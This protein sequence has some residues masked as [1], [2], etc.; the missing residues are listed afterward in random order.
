[1]IQ[2][3]VDQRLLKLVLDNH[4]DGIVIFDN[5]KKTK[6]ANSRLVKLC[7]FPER[8]IAKTEELERK[9]VFSRWWAPPQKKRELPRQNS[10]TLAHLEVLN[11][12][13]FTATPLE[14]GEI[15]GPLTFLNLLK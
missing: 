4:A 2:H 15:E 13:L 12:P 9:T 8:I 14:E 11:K 6:Y 1:M 10:G 7:N 3:T 5:E